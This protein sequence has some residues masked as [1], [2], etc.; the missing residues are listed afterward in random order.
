MGGR[1]GIVV[2]IDGSAAADRALEF[3]MTEAEQTAEALS[4]VHTWQP[5]PL[6]VAMDAYP[7]GYLAGAQRLAEEVV[8]TTLAKHEP[9]HPHLDIHRIV[10]RG[11]PAHR[12][13][14]LARTSRMAV[15]GSHGRGAIARF[16]LGSTSQAVLEEMSTVIVVVK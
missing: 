15:V 13:G 7:Q 3:A 16:F 14:E 8:R 1:S 12:I 6:P 10:E 9:S 5:V 11:F 2:G 4:V